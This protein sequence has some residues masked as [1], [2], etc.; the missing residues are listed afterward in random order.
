ML[1]G[2][3]LSNRMENRHFGKK[4]KTH[5]GIGIIFSLSV[6][7]MLSFAVLFSSITNPAAIA[8]G[9]N[10]TITPPTQA[11]D[12]FS[13]NGVLINLLHKLILVEHLLF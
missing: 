1:N 8:Q 2:V 9:G 12:T 11:T 10:A 3:D 6:V 7:V 4:N 13:A 5:T